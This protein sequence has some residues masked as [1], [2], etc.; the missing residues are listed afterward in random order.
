MDSWNPN[1]GAVIGLT[2]KK[3]AVQDSFESLAIGRF[4]H[5]KLLWLPF[6]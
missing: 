5:R 1:Q 6:H 4:L 3:G 2:C